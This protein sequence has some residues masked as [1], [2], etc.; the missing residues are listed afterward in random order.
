MCQVIAA[1]ALARFGSKA[2][3]NQVNALLLKDSDNFTTS[4]IATIHSIKVAKWINHV[5]SDNAC[6]CL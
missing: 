4:T 5:P 2:M 3:A 6:T 1:M